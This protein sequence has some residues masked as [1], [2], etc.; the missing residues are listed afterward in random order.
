M[1][2][3]T[4]V[5]IIA[6]L[7]TAHFGWGQGPAE[8][9]LEARGVTFYAPFDEG[10]TAV[11]ARGNPEP[12]NLINAQLIEGI[13]GQAVFTQKD[14]ERE[15]GKVA[16]RATSLNYDATGHLHGER[17][18]LA[19]WFQP[20][21]DLDDPKIRSGSNSTGPYL[22]NV[23]SVEDT[24]YQQFIR[25]NIK[26]GSFYMWLV[27]REGGQHG[28]NYGEGVRTWKAGRWYH[29]VMTWDA[30][31]GMRFYA[32]GELKHSTWGDG[33]YPP[34]TPLG[35]GVGGTAPTSRPGWTRAADAAFDELVMLDRAVSD[36][37]VIAL[38]EGRLQDLDE[39]E[40]VAYSAV[41]LDE[42]RR[43][44]L[45]EDDPRRI[46]IVAEDEEAALTVNSLQPTEIEMRYIK[47][48]LLADGR[49]EP[50]VRF[51]QGGV[52]MQRDASFDFADQGQ[53]NYATIVGRPPDG[54]Q[55]Q[56]PEQRL[57]PQ[58]TAAGAARSEL[59][60]VAKPRL[61]IPGGA[62]VGGVQFFD[63]QEGA[64]TESM[65]TWRLAGVGSAQHLASPRETPESL[66]AE[67]EDYPEIVAQI[68]EQASLL[69]QNLDPEDRRLLIPADGEAA[70][71]EVAATRRIYLAGET[72]DADS[73]T[74]ALRVRMPMAGDADAQV[75]R[76]TV[77]HPYE[78]NAF[79]ATADA[80][81]QWQGGG[82]H[83]LDF[84]LRVPGMVFPAGSRPLVE[85]VSSEDF[86]LAGTPELS[87]EIVPA[88]DEAAAF[89]R[90]YTRL[91]NEEYTSRMGVNFKFYLR[92][93][94]RDSTLTRGVFR[95]LHFDPD[96]ERAWEMAR[97]AKFRPWPEWTEQP[98]GPEAFPL[99]ARYA[100]EAAIAARDTIHWWIDERQD[101]TGYMVGRADRWN[102]DTK[103]F[104]EYSFLWLLTGDEKLA[105]AME[106]YLAAHWASGR[107]LKGWSE[108]FTDIVHSAEEA[109]YLEPTMALVRYGDP[110][111]IEQIMQTASNIDDWTGM[112]GP[113]HRHFRSNFFTAE[114]MKTEGHFGHDVGLN[115]TAMVSS[116][117]LAWYNDHPTASEQMTEWMQ[118]WVEDSLVE[119]EDKPAGVI[120]AWVDFETH[121]IGPD[122]ET[123]ISQ[124]SMMMNAAYQHT[125]D[126]W[127]LQP[128]QGYLER[129]Y[130]RWP[131]VLN[132]AAVDLRRAIGDGPWDELLLAGADARHQRIQDD[133]FFQRGLYYDELPGVLGW[134]I[135][136]DVGYLEAVCLNAWRNNERALPI[137]TEVDAHKDRVYPWARY[138]LPWMY[139]GGNA[140]NDRGSAP[141]PTIAVSWDAEYDFAALVRE[142]EPDHLRITAWNFGDAGDVGMKPWG[143]QP[144]TWRLTVGDAEAREVQI[145]RGI[146]VPIVL[147]KQA[148]VEITLDLVEADNWSPLRPD[149]ALSSTEGARVEDGTLTV[150]AHNIGSRQTPA[151]AATLSADGEV[152]A[153]AQ[154]PTIPAP[155]DFQPKIAEVSF[156]LPAGATGE[157]TVM[158]DAEGAIA[159]ITEVNNAMA[160]EVR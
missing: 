23:S 117:W 124:L 37:E 24:Y 11:H 65:T 150:I 87:A 120:P 58:T 89:A 46:T 77:P 127:F 22:V 41:Q 159:E 49:F 72:M 134:M 67:Q 153:E 91:V 160:V 64:P 149:L 35:I 52:I 1:R 136:G 82:E 144:G 19:Y 44:F 96:N 116:M 129:E 9:E 118:A 130:D 137:Y 53:P 99:T 83:V 138:V 59:S 81:V 156:D 135:T 31:E 158:L 16:G 143:L 21:Y 128:L 107:M 32:D 121:Q 152:I 2:R 92:G 66:T 140:L 62:S 33:A 10:V 60:P 132:M 36:D 68:T 14:R 93:E 29:I 75:F 106:Q 113:N 111:H 71:M 76:L 40:E 154:V 141:W 56:F 3:T 26:A 104:N 18:T 30:S 80:Q 86:A 146:A 97:W 85:I 84:T 105:E 17:G 6:A 34:A 102:D 151:C 13:R 50:A 5:I 78:P 7:A 126:E 115:A 101:E 155:L 133:E 157:M 15:L 103:L 108:P 90:Q 145:E 54:A 61:L 69:L 39:A 48:A 139:C 148:E 112:T 42:R 142:W 51:E 122:R 20:H 94:D 125:G 110:L 43:S 28:A 27:D 95:A 63:V 47:S 88:A 100:R 25:A 131:Q 98:S 109:S 55:F 70:A 147:A 57:A 73:A 79:Y 38:M 123:Y 114:Q 8:E 119:A 12:T 45:I 4:I 74:R